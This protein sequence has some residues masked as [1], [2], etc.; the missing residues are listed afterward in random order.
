MEFRWIEWNIDMVGD[1]GVTPEEAEHV[2]EHAGNPYPQHR[3][4][5]KFLVWGP[6]AV[7]RLL[8]V[9]F[10][11]DEDDTVFIIHARPLP[12]KEKRR[13]RKRES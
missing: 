6:T 12:D 8:Q 2:V 7:G 5:D 9:V 1:H 3:G 4:D 11:L 13:R 10:L